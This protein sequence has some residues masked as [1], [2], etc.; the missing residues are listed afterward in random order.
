MELRLSRTY[1]G[2]AASRATAMRL[3]AHC[4]RMDFSVS[5]QQ[6]PM[7]LRVLRLGLALYLGEL[8]DITS[9]LLVLDILLFFI[10]YYYII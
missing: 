4:G 6:L 2:L 1:A 3:D 5:D 8:K 9:M 10:N 7:L